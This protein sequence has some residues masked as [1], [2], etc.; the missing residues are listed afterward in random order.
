MR[1]IC[2][3]FF[4]CKKT[5]LFGNFIEN[6]PNEDKKFEFN[7]FEKARQVILSVSQIGQAKFVYG[8]SVLDWSQF[9]LLPQVPQKM[10]LA[11][12]VVKNNHLATLI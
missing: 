7:F 6:G 1:I 8:G 11:S 9:L 4:V 3:K 5:F 10:S 12:K 2:C